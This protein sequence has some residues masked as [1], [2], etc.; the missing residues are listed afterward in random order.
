MWGLF[1]LRF[2]TKDHVTTRKRIMPTNSKKNSLNFCI[3][4]K[5]YFFASILVRGH[6][7]EARMNGSARYSGPNGCGIKLPIAT[8]T[9]KKATMPTHQK[10][11]DF[12]SNTD[13]KI[14]IADDLE[15]YPKALRG[16]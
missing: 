14:S 11:I 2:L 16:L 6:E 4:G 10:I 7:R 8:Q 5:C 12:I 3:T 13:K 9:V 15:L 1:L